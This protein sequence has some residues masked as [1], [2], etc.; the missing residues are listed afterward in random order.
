MSG[1]P[2]M[3]A[4]LPLFQ[5]DSFASKP[6]TGNPSAV[7]FLPGPRDASWMQQVAGEMISSQPRFPHPEADGYHLR[8]FTPTV[9]VDLCGHA[10]LASAHILWE[11]RR[12]STGD[13]AHFH[14]R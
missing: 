10:T 11:E 7:C 13:E 14:T 5:V 8:W 2:V 9:E 6:F 3:A 12:L 1:E 4:G